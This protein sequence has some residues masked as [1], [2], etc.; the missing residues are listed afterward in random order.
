M[1]I[2]NTPEE[3]PVIA[4]LGMLL[5]IASD[6]GFGRLGDDFAS[7]SPRPFFRVSCAAQL[8]HAEMPG[9]VRPPIPGEILPRSTPGT[10]LS[11]PNPGRQTCCPDSARM[12]RN[13]CDAE[14]KKS[15]SSVF[16]SLSRPIRPIRPSISASPLQLVAKRVKRCLLVAHNAAHRLWGQ[17]PSTLGARWAA[18]PCDPQPNPAALLA[19]DQEL[20]A[21]TG[22]WQSSP[23]HPLS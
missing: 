13:I 18:N 8:P 22:P 12:S 11:R 19:S 9:L 17:S 10:G 4:T 15:G 5:H 3:S 14:A 7:Q 16:S 20:Q 21:T 2:G 23:G 6:S 1:K